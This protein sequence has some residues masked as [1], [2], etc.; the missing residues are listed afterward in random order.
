MLILFAKRQILGGFAL[1]ELLTVIGIILI[2][3]SFL[4]PQLNLFKSRNILDSTAQEIIS[5]LR[6]AQNK[7]VASEGASSFGVHFETDKFILFKGTIY[8][9]AASDNKAYALAPSLIIDNL[10]LEN[11]SAEI[12]FERLT[13]KALSFGSLNLRFRDDSSETRTIYASSQGVI[14]LEDNVP[15]D[16]MR[17]RDSRRVRVLYSQ[18]TKNAITLTLDFFADGVSQNINYPSFLNATQDSFDWS[19]TIAVNG[20]DQA[21]RIHSLSL[22]SSATLFCIHR[23]R[24]YNSK[25]IS[26]SLDGQNIISYS[27]TGTTTPGTSVWVGAPE[28]Q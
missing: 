23:D 24:R 7:T 5:A 18:N 10:D 13:G 12:I 11:N 14:S 21:I 26:L 25:A 27:A 1:I 4:F 20:A 2:L 22:D 28:I 15:N 8:D 16:S 3:A 9:S 17:L 19:G 6:L